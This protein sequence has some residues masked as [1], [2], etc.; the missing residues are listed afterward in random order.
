[1]EGIA[2]VRGRDGCPELLEP[3][4]SS[5]SESSSPPCA[6]ADEPYATSHHALCMICSMITECPDVYICLSAY[7]NGIHHYSKFGQVRPVT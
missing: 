1:M 5:Y 4:Q 6:I 2:N 7:I 3:S